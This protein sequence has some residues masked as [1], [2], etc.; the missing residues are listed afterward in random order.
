MAATVRGEAAAVVARGAGRS[1]CTAAAL[2]NDG[3]TITSALGTIGSGGTPPRNA[4]VAGSS[5]AIY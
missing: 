2:E 5:Y 1:V 4:G 3:G